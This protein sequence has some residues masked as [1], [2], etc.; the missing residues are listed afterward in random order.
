[1]PH[2]IL[3]ST[4]DLFDGGVFVEEA[5][6]ELV[7]VSQ[8]VEVEAGDPFTASP[9]QGAFYTQTVRRKTDLSD[10]IRQAGHR[11][12]IC[13]VTT[14]DRTEQLDL[15]VNGLG[16]RRLPEESSLQRIERLGERI[17]EVLHEISQELDDTPWW[18][19]GIG[20]DVHCPHD[21]RT[22]HAKFMWV[23]IHFCKKCWLA[24]RYRAAD[25][26]EWAQL[27]V[28]IAG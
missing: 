5:D 19:P 4:A 12:T 13:R 20:A 8:D 11:G 2:A 3:N 26:D 21:N 28:L 27:K 23:D 16:A 1:M 9:K 25:Y 10:L 18:D 24:I 6:V 7:A 17:F 14:L 15:L 22:N